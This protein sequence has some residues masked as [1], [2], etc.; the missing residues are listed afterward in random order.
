ML[1]Q[2][3]LS[4]IDAQ[5]ENRSMSYAKPGALQN[6]LMGTVTSEKFKQHQMQNS[7]GFQTKNMLDQMSDI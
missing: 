5:S 7:I 3:D 2:D 1:N 6:N 4:E